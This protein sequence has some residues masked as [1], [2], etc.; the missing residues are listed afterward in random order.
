MRLDLHKL[1]SL[2]KYD[3]ELCH[4]LCRSH[5]KEFT[6]WWDATKFNWEYASE[7]LAKYCHEYFE[8]WWDAT[9]FDWESGSANLTRYCHE[10]FKKWWNPTRFIYNPESLYGLVKNLAHHVNEWFN[11][12]DMI[13]ALPVPGS[14]GNCMDL[15]D[16]LKILPHDKKIELI[17]ELYRVQYDMN[18]IDIDKDLLDQARLV[19]TLD[20]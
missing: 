16:L 3:R 6:R 13:S 4:H 14:F 18:E 15:C 12:Q 9:K 8:I 11:I 5:K 20:A 10:Y 7:D 2:D 1:S 17:A 19:A